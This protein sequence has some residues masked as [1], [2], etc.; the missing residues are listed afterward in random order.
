MSSIEKLL[1]IAV[2]NPAQYVVDFGLK[3]DNSSNQISKAGKAPNAIG[4]I[5]YQADLGLPVGEEWNS[6][7][8]D[9]KNKLK[10]T[11]DFVVE[12]RKF[13]IEMYWKRATYFWA[14]IAVIFAGFV[15]LEKSG[16]ESSFEAFL[17]ICLGFIV[18]VAWHLT[19]LGSKFWQRHWEK[20]LDLLEDPF[21][22]PLYKTVN[23]VRSYSVSKINTIVSFA[24]SSAWLILGVKHSFT[25]FVPFWSTK[26]TKLNWEVT[27][28]TVVVSLVITSMFFGYGRG[29]FRTQN[30]QM[31][32]REY[33]YKR[34][35]T[36]E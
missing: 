15:G 16:S 12:T 17:L 7:S 2:V 4:E 25:F 9:K 11:F 34:K 18:S 20:H 26:F 22:G 13:E 29:R 21:V 1:W 19:N 33:N 32:R 28:L 14:F 23:G 36:N 31:Y 35:Q 30:I 27:I 10:R 24:F 6:L 3:F 8:A 5:Q